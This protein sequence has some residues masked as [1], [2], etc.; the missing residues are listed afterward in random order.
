MKLP[1]KPSSVIP[2]PKLALLQTVLMMIL[3]DARTLAF[4]PLNTRSNS[5]LSF[6]STAPFQYNRNQ[7]ACFDFYMVP[8]EATSTSS[9]ISSSSTTYGDISPKYPTQRGTTVDSRKIIE[10]SGGKRHLTAVRLSH[11][12]FLSN[13]LATMS[14]SRLR[15]AEI[16]FDDL[17]AQISNCAETREEGGS[18]GW[19]SCSEGDGLNEHLDGFFP[20]EA[21]QKVLE[22]STKV[23]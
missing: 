3:Y 1:S 23:R 4:Q 13:D 2:V 16:T 6:P 12:L 10:E 17:A 21:R 11:I 22:A 20:P 18:I 8:P 19:V 14:L 9:T 5:G 15:K 7:A